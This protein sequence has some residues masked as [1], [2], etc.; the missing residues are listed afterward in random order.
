[1]AQ[2]DLATLKT[3]IDLRD[4][5]MREKYLEVAN[6]PEFA[7]AVLTNLEINRLEGKTEFRGTLRLHGVEKAV[8]GTANVRSSDREVRVT[9]EF[10]ISLNEFQI[11]SPRYLGVG[12]ADRVIV[13]A[14]ISAASESEREYQ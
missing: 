1:M 9:A 2:V 13:K 12:V 7:Q 5:H 3:G 11:A 6:G 14:T 8:G 4:R 10:P